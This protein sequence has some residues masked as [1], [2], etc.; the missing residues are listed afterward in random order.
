MIENEFVAKVE[1][2]RNYWTYNKLLRQLGGS[3]ALRVNYSQPHRQPSVSPSQNY[4]CPY[5]IVSKLGQMFGRKDGQKV[6]L[7]LE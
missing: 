5:I 3:V 6:V 4:V 2:T 7:V 1:E